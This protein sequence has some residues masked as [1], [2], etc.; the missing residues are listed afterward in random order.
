MG[1]PG[2]GKGPQARR[3]IS[4]YGYGRSFNGYGLGS[5]SGGHFKVADVCD[6]GCGAG[7]PP[8]MAPPHL[9]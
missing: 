7:D 4:R 1:L 3:L 8:K 6:T 9:Y 5:W 2:S